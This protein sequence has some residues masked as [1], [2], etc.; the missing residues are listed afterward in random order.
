MRWRCPLQGWAIASGC[1][2]SVLCLTWDRL[3]SITLF[4]PGILPGPSSETS[5]LVDTPQLNLLW[6]VFQEWNGSSLNGFLWLNPSSILLPRPRKVLLLT[7][8]RS[9]NFWLLLFPSASAL[10]FLLSPPLAHTSW[11]LLYFQVCS[12]SVF[13]LPL[14]LL[15]SGLLIYNKQRNSMKRKIQGKNLT[16]LAGKG[17]LACKKTFRVM[18]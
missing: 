3:S 16:K 17:N 11:V 7:S 12:C 14:S 10:Q 1:L 9:N 2:H 4:Y 13:F 5:A 15:P 6:C 18:E 8:R